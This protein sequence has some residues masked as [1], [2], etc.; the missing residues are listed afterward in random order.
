MTGEGGVCKLACKTLKQQ[1][2]FVPDNHLF[3]LLV[4]DIEK[5]FVGY[6]E[7][8]SATGKTRKLSDIFFPMDVQS[9]QS[10]RAT[11]T[12]AF[13]SLSHEHELRPPAMDTAG[14]LT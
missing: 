14:G 5:D 9:R 2:T 7:P 12:I 10:Q 8:I 6:Q 3:G 11:T 4:T 1:M 13:F